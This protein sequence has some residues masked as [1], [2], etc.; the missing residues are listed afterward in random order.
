M[1]TL[2]EIKRIWS[3]PTSL[4]RKVDCACSRANIPPAPT[5]GD[6]YFLTYNGENNTYVWISLS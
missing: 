6:S 1:S 2:I 4:K 5:D 3:T